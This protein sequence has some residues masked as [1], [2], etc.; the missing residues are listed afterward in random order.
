M[1]HRPAHP[2]A[3][4]R[5]GQGRRDGLRPGAQHQAARRAPRPLPRD[6]EL[7]RP[8][9]GGFTPAART[10]LHEGQPELPPQLTG[11][12]RGGAGL[13]AIVERLAEITERAVAWQD[14]EGAVRHA[15]T[16][17]QQPAVLEALEADHA[18]VRR[19]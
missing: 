10:L 18:A 7:R 12:A 9:W 11:R 14:L 4:L 6:A 2:A 19:W 13:P 3:R 5:V 15:S 16:G 1:G 8:R 17:A